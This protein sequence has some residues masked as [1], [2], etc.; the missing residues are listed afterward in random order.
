MLRAGN[1]TPV[2]KFRSANSC[3][4]DCHPVTSSSVLFKVFKHLLAKNLNNFAE[5]KNLFPNLKLVSAK[6]LVP[7]MP[8]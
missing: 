7:M 3:P 8:F 2:S 4:S 5:K 6:V 1:V